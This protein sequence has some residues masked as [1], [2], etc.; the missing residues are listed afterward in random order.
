VY[1]NR[2]VFYSIGNFAF[3]S[4]NSKA[5]AVLPGIDFQDDFTGITISPAYIKNRDKR[6]YYQPKI[7]SGI[8]A[9]K[10]IKH[11]KEISGASGNLIS[12]KNDTGE[13]VI[14]R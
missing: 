5:E 3:G 11:L 10:S 6:I 9:L 14:S 4:G 12:L 8:S 2:P 7:L 1:K 13:I